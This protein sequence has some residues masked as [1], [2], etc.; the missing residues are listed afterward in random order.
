MFPQEP[1]A[2]TAPTENAVLAPPTPE[3]P[4]I[5]PTCSTTKGNPRRRRS[6]DTAAAIVVAIVVIGL[7]LLARTGAFSPKSA[8]VDARLPVPT[9]TAVLQKNAAAVT[10][11]RMVYVSRTGTKYHDSAVCSNMKSPLYMTLE[12]A[13][14]RGR[15][16]CSKC[17]R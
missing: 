16:A 1:P 10:Q 11:E 2:K 8:P 3:A 12:E 4:R 14:G 5:T 17:V 7:L 9:A 15:T 6:Y 13:K